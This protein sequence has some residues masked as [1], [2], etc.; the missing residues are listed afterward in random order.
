[1]SLIFAYISG[2]NIN[3]MLFGSLFA[4]V[5]ISFILVFALRSW[6]MGLMSLVPNLV[7]AA[8]ALGVWGYLVGVAGLSVAVVVAITLGIVV[9]D[10]VHF[11]SK[12]LRAKREMGL[13]SAAA[14]K[15]AF[16]TVGVA[17]WITSI[18]LMAGFAIL[19]L[20]GFKVT[21]EMG[22]LSAVTIGLALLADFFFLPPLLL[23][24]DKE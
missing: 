7:P 6:R 2:R 24:F 16:S 20:S 8:M 22:L 18:T 10:T 12:Y 4:L 3:S 11:L 13:S 5:V 9:D 21:A 19:A 14:V 15:F 23:F 17:L 1:M